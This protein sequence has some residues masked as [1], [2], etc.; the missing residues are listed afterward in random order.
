MRASN[1]HI[2]LFSTTVLA[3]CYYDREEE[4]Y[5]GSAVCETTSVTWSATVQPLIQ[6]RC[7]TAG[8]HVSGGFGPGDFTQYAN[9]KA[10]VDDGR[11]QAE[12][13]QAGSMPPTGRL[14][15]CD[16]QKLQVWIDAGAPNN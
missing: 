4:L 2:L 1:V 10:K 11:F 15:D 13:I 8:C 16:I 6:A 5:P 14:S 9:V 7:A 12:V 3:G